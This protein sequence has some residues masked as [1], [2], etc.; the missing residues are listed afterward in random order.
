MAQRTKGRGALPIATPK[1]AA[2]AIH[3]LTASGA[4]A[5]M[6][7]LQAT[8]DNRIRNA[9]L[10]LIVAQVLDGIDGPIA[11]RLDVGV[12]APEVDGHILDLVVDYVTCVVVPVAL[13]I[14]LH[15]LPKHQ[16]AWIAGL[17]LF[18][19]A[20]WFS[21]T[22]QETPDHWFNGF[23]AGWNVVVPTFLILGLNSHQVAWI[24]LILCI[25]QLTT[26]KT[27]HLVRVVFMRQVTLPLAVIYFAVLTYLSAM[28][29]TASFDSAKSWGSWILIAFPTYVLVL[30]VY[31]T[32]LAKPAKRSRPRPRN[33][34]KT[35]RS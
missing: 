4:I 1:N 13:L 3:A 5:G 7:A 24:S 21:R 31:R 10:W 23:A 19:S 11:R 17:I 26:L 29:G 20:L 2:L 34:T 12:H 30:S 16:E 14:H 8:I 15:L 6:L 25:M 27:P 32:W 28:Y 9:L 22:D 18:T 33:G 35:R